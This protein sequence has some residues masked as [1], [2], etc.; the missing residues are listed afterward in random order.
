MERA[1]VVRCH[2]T[3]ESIVEEVIRREYDKRRQPVS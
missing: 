3:V 1:G 2:V